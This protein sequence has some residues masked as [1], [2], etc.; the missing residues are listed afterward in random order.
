MIPDISI[1]NYKL[2][3]KMSNYQKAVS[4]LDAFSQAIESYWS[5]N[6]NSESGR[7]FN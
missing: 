3:F 2:S 6:S 7:I 1:I 4:G 5:L